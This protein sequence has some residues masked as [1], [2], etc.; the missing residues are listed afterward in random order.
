MLAMASRSSVERMCG[1]RL[2]SAM[3]SIASSRSAT[4]SSGGGRD[5]DRRKAA[6][7]SEQDRQ[8]GENDN[9]QRGGDQ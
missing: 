5:E 6:I 3:A 1:M 7:V 8:P 9:D 4:N 2:A